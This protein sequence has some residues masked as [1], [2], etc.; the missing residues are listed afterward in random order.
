MP[1]VNCIV[2]EMVIYTFIGSHTRIHVWQRLMSY[3][4][5]TP[6]LPA[7]ATGMCLLE[8]LLSSNERMVR[9]LIPDRREDAGAVDLDHRQCLM[10]YLQ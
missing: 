4:G 6:A 1:A 8:D 5:R 9:H 10:E 7:W 2:S 3:T